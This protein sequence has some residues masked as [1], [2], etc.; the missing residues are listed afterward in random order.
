MPMKTSTRFVKAAILNVCTSLALCVLCEWLAIY[1]FHTAQ[2]APGQAWIWPMFWIN[3]A[4]AWC[5][6]TIIGMMPSVTERGVRW[7]M[8]RAKP[9]DGAKFGALVNVPINTVYSVVLCY[10]VGALDACVLGGAPLIASV[11]GFLQNIVPVWIACFV[12]TFPLQGRIEGLARK[13]MN[14]PAPRMA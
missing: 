10:L 4:F 7:A 5:V 13:V 2:P 8:K 9:E 14:D 1:V 12:V 3:F 11:F 6:A